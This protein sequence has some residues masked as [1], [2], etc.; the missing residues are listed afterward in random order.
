MNNIVEKSPDPMIIHSHGIVKVINEEARK[1]LGLKNAKEIIGKEIIKYVHKDHT[2]LVLERINTV[3]TWQE[4]ARFI[5]EK[6]L[7]SDGSF[8]D[9]EVS[10]SAFY[11][12]GKRYVQVIARDISRKK[13]VEQDLIKSK[14]RYKKLYNNINDMVFMMKFSENVAEHTL[15]E[16]NNIMCKKLLYEKGELLKL[17]VKDLIVDLDDNKIK[18][19]V[20]NLIRK[21]SFIFESNHRKKDGTIIPVEINAIVVTIKGEKHI[22]NV[23]RDIS[24]R[25]NSEKI[26]KDIEEKTFQLNEALEYDKLRTEFFAN[27]SHELRTPINVIYS[28]VQL[29]EMMIKGDMFNNNPK[30]VND[31][32]GM[33]KQNCFRLIR[34]INN[35][36]DVTK[37]DSGYFELQLRN[38]NIISI[39]ENITLSVADYIESKGISL[40]FDTDIEE[41]IL[42]CDDEK[43][44]RIILNLLSNSI[45][46]TE[47]GGKIEVDIKDKKTYV[48]IIVKDTGIGIPEEKQK[49]IFD[50][51]VQADKSLAR[52]N[53]G[54]GI[55][56]SLVRELVRLHGGRISLK[57]ELSVGSE[58]LI[59]LPIKLVENNKTNVSKFDNNTDVQNINI[60]FSDIYF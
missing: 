47:T 11:H 5:E 15:M 52:E 49:Y 34:I 17:N 9:V 37:I 40:E 45:K 48:Q 36:I 13:L 16:V 25:L 32:M 29:V 43:I 55:G 18:N 22:L 8:V 2:E 6:L 53:E 24:E 46:F 41:K 19:I 39:V 23:S 56:L 57:S 35:L 14:N 60:E 26:K 3:S 54:S 27:I 30:K 59:E 20:N 10:S 21:G 51:F 7:K 42:A 33:M 44:E 28:T 50:R 4:S 12:K 38:Q 58:F 31:Y 1:L